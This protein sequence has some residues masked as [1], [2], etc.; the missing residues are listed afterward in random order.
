MKVT[1]WKGGTYGIRVG[2]AN[3]HKFFKKEW[4]NI[5]VE[6]NG[7]FYKFKLSPTFWMTCPEFRGKSIS[8]WLLSH[9]LI[10]WPKGKPP[11]LELVPIGGNCFRLTEPYIYFAYGSNMDINRMISRKISFSAFE[12]AVLNDYKLIFNK[13]ASKKEG[14]GYANIKKSKNIKVIG[15]VYTLAEDFSKLDIYEGHPT[16]YIRIKVKINKRIGNETVIATTYIANPKKI[17]DGL[18]PEKNYLQHLINGASQHSFPQDYIKYLK[19]VET[20]Y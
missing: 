3:A 9:K 13:K 5:E 20:R 15:V 6:I 12:T 14:I 11:I 4:E 16:H 17:I 1:A 2:K 10:S 19:C 7:V 18:K 8:A